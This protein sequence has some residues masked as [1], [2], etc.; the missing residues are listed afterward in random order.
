M[1]DRGEANRCRPQATGSERGTD[2]PVLAKLRDDTEEFRCAVMIDSHPKVKH[3][4]RN[5]ER[6]IQGAF[7]LPTSYGKFFP[8]FVCELKDGRNIQHR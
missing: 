4:V 1:S 3:W 2:Y 6:D 8:D 5:L 7:W